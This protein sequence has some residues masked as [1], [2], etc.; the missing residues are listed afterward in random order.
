MGLG[1]L[2]IRMLPSMCGGLGSIPLLAYPPTKTNKQ[3]KTREN[4]AIREFSKNRTKARE[5]WLLLVNLPNQ[6]L[7]FLHFF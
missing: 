1:L 6:M 3:T 5:V 4:K 2:G 7:I